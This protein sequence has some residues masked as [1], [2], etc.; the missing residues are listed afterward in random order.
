VAQQTP[1]GRCRRDGKAVATVG[2]SILGLY[3]P[4]QPD[5]LANTLTPVVGDANAQT[6]EF[7]S[8]S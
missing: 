6:P 2:N 5:F 8:S 1:D 7:K 3:P 4:R